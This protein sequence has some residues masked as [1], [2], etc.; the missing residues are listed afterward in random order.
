MQAAYS[1]RKFRE[2]I[3][4]VH[5]HP[6]RGRPGMSLVDKRDTPELIKS[7]QNVSPQACH[8]AIIFSRDHGAAWIRE[9]GS[10]DV[11]EAARVRVVGH[12]IGIFEGGGLR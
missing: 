7:F 9:P 2:G 10:G 8:G 12:P 3:F 6:H 11:I 1:G 5:E 4:H